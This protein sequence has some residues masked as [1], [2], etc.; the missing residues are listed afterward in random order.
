MKKEAVLL[1]FTLLSSRD[2][3]VGKRTVWKCV[4]E[5]KIRLVPALILNDPNFIQLMWC[6]RAKE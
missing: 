3:S 1:H 4:K 6:R 2:S 5:K